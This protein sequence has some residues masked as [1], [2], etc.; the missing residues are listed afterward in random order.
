MA[1]SATVEEPASFLA[2]FVDSLNIAVASQGF[3]IALFPIYSSMTREKRPRFMCSVS[4]GLM[5]TFSCYTY[6]SL[7]SIA[8]FGEENIAPSIFN[9]IKGVEGIPSILLRCVFLM[10]FFCNIPFIFFAGKVALMAIVYQCI[11]AKKEPGR[12]TQ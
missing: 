10:I 2:S 6:L 3:V 9:N 7:I 5:F 12:V 8:Y 4:A 11:Y 1:A